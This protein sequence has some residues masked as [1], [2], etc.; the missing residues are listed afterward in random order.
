MGGGGDAHT[1]TRCLPCWTLVHLV[2]L[3][4]VGSKDHTEIQQNWIQIP[5]LGLPSCGHLKGDKGTVSGQL[6]TQTQQLH[7]HFLPYSFLHSVATLRILS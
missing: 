6:D 3:I 5:A 7:G 4:R 1:Q 2:G